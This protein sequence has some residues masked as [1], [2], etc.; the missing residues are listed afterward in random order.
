MKLLVY[1]LGYL[2][3]P[4]IIHLGNKSVILAQSYRPILFGS[5][6]MIVSGVVPIESCCS[7]RATLVIDPSICLYHSG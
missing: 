1:L 3:L 4:L 7:V 5:A 2:S 6:L